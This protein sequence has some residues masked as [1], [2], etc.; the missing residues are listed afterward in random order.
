MFS[1][2]V[3]NLK[4]GATK[5]S[6]A[7]HCAVEGLKRGK[8]VLLIDT[9]APQHSAFVWNKLRSAAGI[10][11][12]SELHVVTS[13]ISKLKGE[14]EKARAAG[15]DLVI[16][17]TAPRLGPEAVDIAKTVDRVVVPVKPE[18]FFLNR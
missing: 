14:I 9:D 12:G 13:T 7:V 2:A 1:I 3:M 10:E 15:Y 6:T 17:D 11:S 18:P 5:S 4:G 8:R 16:V